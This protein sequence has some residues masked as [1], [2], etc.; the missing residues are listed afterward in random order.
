[1]H[2][3]RYCVYIRHFGLEPAHRSRTLETPAG[4]TAPLRTCTSCPQ[5]AVSPPQPLLPQGLI[6][7]LKKS[8]SVH[9]TVLRVDSCE[10]PAQTVLREALEFQALFHHEMGSS[11]EEKSARAAEIRAEVAKTGHY[12]QVHAALVAHAKRK[13]TFTYP[14]QS[15]SGGMRRNGN[16]HCGRLSK[17]RSRFF[18]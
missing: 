1:M 18:D 14:I 3:C 12:T 8:Q 9:Q 4:R 17:H 6:A 13:G 5:R 11:E 16:M 7:R 10:M 2:V 15:D